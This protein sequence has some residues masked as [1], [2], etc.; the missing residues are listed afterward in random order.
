MSGWGGLFTLFVVL[1][2]L[3]FFVIAGLVAVFIS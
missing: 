1:V 3:S 2:V